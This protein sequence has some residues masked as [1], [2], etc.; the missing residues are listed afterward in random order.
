MKEY[1][2]NNK[3]VLFDNN[4]KEKETHPDKTGKATINGEDYWVSAWYNTSKKGVEY[5][6]LSFKLKEE[7]EPALPYA[8]KQL[9]E[10]DAREVIKD[11]DIPF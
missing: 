2:N 5:I 7:E 1:D 4:K 8:I 11:D 3:G 6:N 9:Q 10:E